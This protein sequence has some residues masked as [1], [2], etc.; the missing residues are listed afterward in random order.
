MLPGRQESWRRDP[1]AGALVIVVGAGLAG[2]VALGVMLLAIPAF[3]EL[4]EAA[5]AAIRSIDLPGLVPFAKFATWVGSFWPMAAITAGTA[6]V[7]LVRGRRTTAI[8]LTLAVLLGAGVANALKLVFMRERP[9][10]IALIPSLESY[11]FPS[12]HAVASF[13]YFAMLGFLLMVHRRSL[14]RAFLGLVLCVLAAGAIALSRVYLGV[15]FFYDAVGG[16][17]LG[18]A[19]VAFVVLVGARWAA[20]R[21]EDDEV[22][23]PAEA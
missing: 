1:R 21:P 18:I 4:D 10:V 22:S 8:M 12:G 20:G 16:W 23:G 5:S 6:L 7:Y 19:W 17:L 15:H 11:S 13:V 9:D 3:V 14:K 2:F